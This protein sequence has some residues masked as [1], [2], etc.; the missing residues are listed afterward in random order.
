LVDLRSGGLGTSLL[1]W[2]ARVHPRVPIVAL[3]NSVE[4]ATAA[5]RS[6]VLSAVPGEA[7]AV[8]AC[9]RRLIEDRLRLLSP[10]AESPQPARHPDR[11]LRP[12]S[13]P[14][15]GAYW[16][17]VA[18][19]LLYLV[20]ESVE[21]AVMFLIRGRSLT[22][23]GA[24]GEGSS[25]APLAATTAHLE[26][27]LTPG[28]VLFEAVQAGA[29]RSADFDAARLDPRLIEI[30]G[31]PRTERVVAF[32]V[33]GAGRVISVIYA[34]N[35]Q[36]DQPIEEVGQLEMAVGLAGVVLEPE[37]AASERETTAVS[38]AP[39]AVPEAPI[40]TP[41]AP[42][43]VPEA[44]A[45]AEPE[46]AGDRE[47]SRA[48]L[49]AGLAALLVVGVLA[50]LG[51]LSYFRNDDVPSPTDGGGATA[52][53]LAPPSAS[54][55]DGSQLEV[56][57]QTRGPG[58]ATLDERA[59]P[60][61]AP[62]AVAS[63]P[64]HLERITWRETDSE[65]VLTLVADGPFEPGGYTIARLEEGPPRE[66][67]RVAGVTRP[68]FMSTLPVGTSHLIR[69]RTGLQADTDPPEMHVVADLATAAVHVIGVELAGDAL[70]IRF[71]LG[72][73][74]LSAA[75]SGLGPTGC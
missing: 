66:V 26:I 19:N 51:V 58:A 67:I 31:R 28:S 47:P 3:V 52:E 64:I 2:L 20:S 53:A 37:W 59:S 27:D 38:E 23:V 42:A 68:F 54:H 39:A 74:Q 29:T 5:Y 16:T 48:R 69:I 45:A 36:L 40:A 10:G 50:A 41:R 21:R 8:E 33:R 18:L 72:A 6:G 14:H 15:T 17:T 25:G 60:I 11:L 62:G 61:A 73:E 75:R 35:G 12:V 9:L 34:D 49:A 46:E 55:S 70:E 24:F 1:A 56:R 4:A 44:P 30:L 63:P 7:D 22:V 71:G 43:A 65:T 32:P 13:D 57:P